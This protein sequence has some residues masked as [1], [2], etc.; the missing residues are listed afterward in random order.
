M[1]LSE[2]TAYAEANY[3]IQEQHKWP[4]FPGFSVLCHP[5]TGKWVALLMRQW[6]MES[7]I[8][9]QRCD[10][11]CGKQSL[12][13]VRKPYLS[14]PVRMKGPKWI[15]VSFGPDTE[16]DVIFRLFDRAVTSGEQR[17]Y[18]M[19]LSS[20][21]HPA[22]D[23]WQDTALPVPAGQR[24][25]AEPETPDR[26]R[27]MRR[28]YEYGRESME[29]KA[30]NFLRQGRFMQD[31]E[32]DAP[33]AGDFSVYFPTYHDLTVRQLRGYFSWRTRVR[34]GEYP[35][36]AAS[37]AYLYLYE[38]LNGIGSTSPED[39]LRKLGA[40]ETGFLDA[41][42]GDARMRQNLR[43]WMLEY[44]VIQDLPRELAQQSADPELL[45]YDAAL[46][47][48]R[49]PEGHSDVEVSDAL[50]RF[51]G[52]R[53]AQSPVLNVEP[54]RGKHLFCEIWRA[55]VRDGSRAEQN[56]FSRCFGQPA[57]RR[58]YPLANAVYCWQTRPKDRLYSFDACRSYRCRNGFW[59]MVAYE[60]Q[61]FD[62]GLF[63]GFLREADRLLRQYLCV[64][65]SL[66]EKPS[67][68]WAAP[69]IRPVI[70]ADRR[71][72]AEAARPKITIDFSGLDRIRQDA[73]TTQNSLLTA[74]E[75]GVA[76][77]AAVA[78]GS[79]EEAPQPHVPAA[80]PHS[81]ESPAPALPVLPEE[82]LPEL[83]LDPLQLQILR[84]L[85]RGDSPEPL[86]RQNRLMP[87][88]VADTINEALFDEIGDTVL[89]CEDDRL[90]L[91]E[92]YCDDLA[93]IL[94][95]NNL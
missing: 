83:P 18:T 64:G 69:L 21:P 53:M 33:W 44:A 45:A 12:M 6:D 59:E 4:D 77:P 17:G 81:P 84:C 61:T 16:P 47:A 93:Q 85:L 22:G 76:E 11:K 48:L 19:V 46:S 87:S 82:Y 68:T 1:E 43:R 94:G 62:R 25:Q 55:G 9:L 66:P 37:A 26:I 41:G 95:G 56:L 34:H 3:Q 42:W 13:E 2:L 35:P 88:I 57:V 23:F 75:A 51:G 29:M 32:D 79:S 30:K 27:Q 58:W 38:L 80:L 39:V 86:I 52:K 63:Q 5:H 90:S 89:S 72:A 70:E 49:N 65:R 73:L 67:D 78:K 10:L 14:A 31:Y 50:C 7:G 20:T 92:D 8:E 91:V 15:S 40:F 24:A 74:E 28:L 54:E 71:A 36:V 60:P